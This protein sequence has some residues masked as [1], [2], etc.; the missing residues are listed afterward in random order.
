MDPTR[1]AQTAEEIKR[2]LPP[3]LERYFEE[4]EKQ[5]ELLKTISPFLNSYYRERVND[6][7]EKIYD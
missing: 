4:K 7:F 2:D 6:Y 5:T 3:D 1:E